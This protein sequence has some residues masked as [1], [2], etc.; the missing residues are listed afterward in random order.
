MSDNNQTL[1][2]PMDLPDIGSDLNPQPNSANPLSTQISFDA[3][4]QVANPVAGS[5]STNPLQQVAVPQQ[6]VSAQQ[7]SGQNTPQTSG[8]AIADDI[9]LIEKEWV[10]KAKEVVDKTKDNPYLQNKAISEM[11][12]DYI[13][14]RYNKDLDKSD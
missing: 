13:K 6:I 5:A 3:T 11:K 10:V 14:K 1:P 8:P 9:D 7:T 2:D 12:A 4:N